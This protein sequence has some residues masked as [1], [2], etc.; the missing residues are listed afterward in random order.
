MSLVKHESKKPE[1]TSP[2]EDGDESEQVAKGSLVGPSTQLR[3]IQR[4]LRTSSGR[5]SSRAGGGRGSA[6]LGARELRRCSLLAGVASPGW[7]GGPGRKAP[8]QEEGGRGR[9]CE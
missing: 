4:S 6:L 1:S 9:S 5:A 7:R 2:R 3:I 8:A